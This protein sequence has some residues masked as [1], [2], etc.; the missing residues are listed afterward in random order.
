M[1]K[2][3]KLEEDINFMREALKCAGQAYGL[4][5][6]PVGAVLVLGGRI[7]ARA[8]N[9]VEMDGDATSH[10]EIKAIR[11]GSVALGGW[12]LQ[13]CTLYTTL[14]PCSMCAGAMFLS[15]VCRV[16]YGAPDLRHGACGTFVDLFEKRHPIHQVLVEGGVLQEECAAIMRQF[17]KERREEKD[18]I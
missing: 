2:E 18:G 7:I 12:R 16:V 3:K 13:D 1:M 4:K 11:A 15:R 5:E 6:V 8:Y 14:E 17:F 10:A 9:T